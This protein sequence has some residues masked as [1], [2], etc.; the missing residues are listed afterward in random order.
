MKTTF[1][2]VLM[3]LSN[4]S[5]IAQ[6]E[7]KEDFSVFRKLYEFDFSSIKIEDTIKT[8]EVV[9]TSFKK[10]KFDNTKVLG[11]ILN[12]LKKYNESFKYVSGFRIQV[13]SG[14][15][16]NRANETQNKLVSKFKSL[17]LS[18]QVY[19]TFDSPTWKIRVGDFNNEIAAHRL[20][21]ILKEDF[22]AAIVL[23]G[24]EVKIEN[25]K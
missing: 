6:D 1:Y 17:G 10:P 3:M 12:Q 5:L 7:L 14:S 22:P 11:E 20:K 19:K 25:I 18:H 15:E 21:H 4:L 8:Q 16:M 24:I 2:L 9:V 23:K 13:Y